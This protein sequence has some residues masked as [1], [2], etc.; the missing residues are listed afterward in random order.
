MKIT[1]WVLPSSSTNVYLK[2]LQRMYQAVLIPGMHPVHVEPV[3]WL[4]CW[5]LVSGIQW[6]DLRRSDLQGGRYDH[7]PSA[8]VVSELMLLVFPNSIQVFRGKPDLE[9]FVLGS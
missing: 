3:D 2:Q 9:D 6:P 5:W 1:E 7:L 8:E 4:A